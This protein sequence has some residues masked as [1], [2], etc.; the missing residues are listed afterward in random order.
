MNTSK[1]YKGNY[2][3]SIAKQ[4]RAGLLET[5][6]NNAFFSIKLKKKYFSWKATYTCC[7]FMTTSAFKLGRTLTIF[8][9]HCRKNTTGVFSCYNCQSSFFESEVGCE[10]IPRVLFE[11]Q[12]F[13]LYFHNETLNWKE[14]K[15]EK[16]ECSEAFDW[17]LFFYNCF[18]FL[19]SRHFI[20]NTTLYVSRQNYVTITNP[21]PKPTPHHLSWSFLESLIVWLFFAFSIFFN[22]F[23]SFACH[24]KAA[25]LNNVCKDPFYPGFQRNLL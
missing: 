14:R 19:F 10:F 18:Y 20:G 5:E 8:D 11:F 24:L 22:V 6:K 12:L 25:L 3:I 7:A 21:K 23:F 16:L 17:Q 2:R 9:F 13:V 15:V 4:K 1:W